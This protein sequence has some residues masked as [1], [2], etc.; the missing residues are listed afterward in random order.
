[1]KLLALDSSAAACS[2]ALWDDREGEAGSPIVAHRSKYMERGQSE[3]LIPLVDSVM[4]ETGWIFS[5]LDR[6]G[7]TVGPGSFTGVRVG[8]AAARGLALAGR[9]PLVGVTSFEAIAFE[10]WAGDGDGSNM[11]PDTLL[12]ALSAG[13]SDL[14][15]QIFARSKIPGAVFPWRLLGPPGA[16]IPEKVPQWFPNEGRVLIAGNGAPLIRAALAKREKTLVTTCS[17]IYAE[18]PSLPDA[19]AVATIAAVRDVEAP[20]SAPAPLYLHSHYAR[21]PQ[22]QVGE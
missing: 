3:A 17:L 13:R 6:L 2:V 22:D 18:G 7:V 12:V 5:D 9:L 4:E 21:L 14:Y 15:I 20:E 10:A 8:L 11:P 1:M 16:A 19:I